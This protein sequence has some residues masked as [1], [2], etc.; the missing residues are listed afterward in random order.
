MTHAELSLL[1][2]L[3]PDRGHHCN[4]RGPNPALCSIAGV[5]AGLGKISSGASDRKLERFLEKKK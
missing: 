5:F 3:L 1:P 4:L 2:E